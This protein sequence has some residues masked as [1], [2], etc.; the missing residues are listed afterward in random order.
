MWSEGVIVATIAAASGILLGIFGMWQAMIKEAAA[1]KQKQQDEETERLKEENK[2]SLEM[3]R[4]QEEME[5]D[6]WL[7]MKTEFSAMQAQIDQQQ[8]QI[9]ANAITIQEQGALIMQ[10]RERIKILEGE[11]DD[12][13]RRAEVAE[14]KHRGTGRNL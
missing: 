13:K 14:S 7:R 6:L 5:R 1:K 11:R 12:W 2:R 3:R 9:N 4:L 10:H 8:K